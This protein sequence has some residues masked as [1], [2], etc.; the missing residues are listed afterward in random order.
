MTGR[1]ETAMRQRA[2]G[3]PSG[4]EEPRPSGPKLALEV[5]YLLLDVREADAYE[6]VSRSRNQGVFLVSAKNA[7]VPVKRDNS[8][9][10][11]LRI[12]TVPRG[13][14]RSE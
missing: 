14:E 12:S 5:P 9:N 6:K 13:S 1:G 3:L 10:T 7:F 11:Y 2:A 4:Y 8:V